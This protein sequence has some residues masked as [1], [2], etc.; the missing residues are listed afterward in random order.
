MTDHFDDL[1]DDIRKVNQIPIVPMMLEV[2]CRTT[3]LGFAAIARVTEN[4]WVA[5][6][7]RDE[8]N[9]GLKAGGEL[10]VETTL[11]NEVRTSEEAIVIDHVARD[12]KYVDHHTP[13]MYGLQSYIAVPIFLRDGSFF[14]TLCAIDP[15]PAS[16][17]NT[18][19]LGL[20][21]LFSELISFHLQNIDLMQKNEKTIA[22]LN[23]EKADAIDEN[24]QF[25]YITHHN[26]AEPLRKLS[27][28]S[29]LLGESA[30]RQDVGKMVDLASKISSLAIDFRSMMK[31]VRIYTELTDNRGRKELIDLN[32]VLEETRSQFNEVISSKGVKIESSNL[33]PV[34]GIRYQIE[35]LFSHLVENSIKF[36]QPGKAPVI[37]I[38]STLCKRNEFNESI[39]LSESDQYLRIEFKD[40][41]KGIESNYVEKIF[42]MFSKFSNDPANSGYG[43][44]LAQCSK[45]VKLHGG[46]LLVESV[47]NEGSKFTVVLPA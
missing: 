6:S 36:A 1:Q 40:N 29:G 20:F 15:N 39:P 2:I 28:F 45:I 4:R 35:L 23:R 5:C 8:I 21:N 22:Q 16:L 10:K 42:N 30:L 27:L 24:Q 3:G 32:D 18:Q 46:A 41:G 31:D 19:T 34:F 43:I 37:S 38:S 7:V 14:G 12:E 17:K 11:C 13:R 25:R 47:V 26:L 33:H 9:F 44:G